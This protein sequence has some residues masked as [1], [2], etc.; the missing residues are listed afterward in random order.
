MKIVSLKILFLI[1]YNCHRFTFPSPPPARIML[2]AIEVLYA[3]GAIDKKGQL[4]NPLGVNMAEIPLRPSLA[5]TL[6]ISGKIN[7]NLIIN[8]H[9]Y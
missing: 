3:L 9:I 5:K 1:V 6:C 2:S 7:I 4:T 8:I